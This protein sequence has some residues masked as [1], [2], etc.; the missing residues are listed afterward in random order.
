[1]CVGQKKIA[2]MLQI[3]LLDYYLFRIISTKKFKF[4][5]LKKNGL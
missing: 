1:M 2:K 4:G 3:Y 5:Y